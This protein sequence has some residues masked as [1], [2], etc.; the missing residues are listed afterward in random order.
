MYKFSCVCQNYN[1]FLCI[2]END[3]YFTSSLFRVNLKWSNVKSISL[4][5]K[6]IKNSAT[7]VLVIKL[8]R[9]PVSIQDD[10]EIM[11]KRRSSKTYI[12]YGFHD[13][14]GV[15]EHIKHYWKTSRSMSQNSFIP[16]K[17]E[18][19]SKEFKDD[20]TSDRK[21]NM[22]PPPQA[23]KPQSLSSVKQVR[24]NSMSKV[25]TLT[26][27]PASD[28][29][30]SPF[31]TKQ[32]SPVQLNN[33]S[34][35]LAEKVSRRPN[36]KISAV[37]YNYMIVLLSRPSL[38]LY[39]LILFLVLIVGVHMFISTGRTVHNPFLET[40]RLFEELEM[41]KENYK[42]FNMH[43]STRVPQ[44]PHGDAF[45][46]LKDS[47]TWLKSLDK[48]VE[49]LLRKYVDLQLEMIDLRQGHME[50]SLSLPS[51]AES[52]ASFD[53]K[54]FYAADS[55]VF[56]NRGAARVELVPRTAHESKEPVQHFMFTRV[57]GIPRTLCSTFLGVF[58][59]F[60]FFSTHQGGYL[61]REGD[62]CALKGRVRYTETFLNDYEI[63][64]YVTLDEANERRQ[65]LRI[66]NELLKVSNLIEELFSRVNSLLLLNRDYEGY[67]YSAGKSQQWNSGGATDSIHESYDMKRA[68]LNPHFTTDDVLH[69]TFLRRYADI[70]LFL[71]PLESS[72]YKRREDAAAAAHKAMLFKELKV[73]HLSGVNHAVLDIVSLLSN[74]FIDSPAQSSVSNAEEVINTALGTFRNLLVELQVWDNH[75]DLWDL[76]LMASLTEEQRKQFLK[77]FHSARSC[78]QSRGSY[79]SGLSSDYLDNLFASAANLSEW[80]YLPIFKG[81][82]CF[83]RRPKLWPTVEHKLLQCNVSTTLPRE[84]WLNAMPSTSY[85]Q[86]NFNQFDEDLPADEVVFKDDEFVL[87]VQDITFKDA[88]RNIY[89]P[90]HVDAA[91]VIVKERWLD[92]L[93]AFPTLFKVDPVDS[94]HTRRFVYMDDD[95]YASRELSALSMRLFNIFDRISYWYIMPLYQSRS[96]FKWLSFPSWAIRSLFGSSYRRHVE[97]ADPFVELSKAQITKIPWRNNSDVPF[98]MIRNFLLRPPGLLEAKMQCER[99]VIINWSGVIIGVVA[100]YAALCFF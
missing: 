3:F 16:E 31:T 43:T 56:F 59:V 61:E 50:R 84:S 23:D 46:P 1:G 10:A 88:C 58:R 60:A 55:S 96:L 20:L 30:P 87:P 45:F 34:Q 75:Q 82:L 14:L 27:Y 95:S 32:I 47:S 41:A 67:L 100:V 99:Q 38:I 65:C 73:K 51:S 83:S 68:L 21:S 94:P 72:E 9:L 24:H 78:T 6:Y 25:P 22:L 89:D 98:N 70:V 53:S 2:S 8:H 39:M 36:Q 19:D 64:Q 52:K 76:H 15:E 74:I 77:A 57:I 69:V 86:H 49:E 79:A 29:R 44:Q 4:D 18:E 42:K 26:A 62:S 37:L 17:G 35:D 92:E 28:R 48:A 63:A 97:A 13:L 90:D 93:A 54:R 66:S 7:S 33:S 5:T 71:N 85:T 81:Q 11:K 91:V 12:F 40:W 80:R